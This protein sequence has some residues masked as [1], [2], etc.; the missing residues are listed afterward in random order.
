MHV[1]KDKPPSTHIPQNDSKSTPFVTFYNMDD[2]NF[3]IQ[4]LVQT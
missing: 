2:K 4:Y 3:I 1:Y